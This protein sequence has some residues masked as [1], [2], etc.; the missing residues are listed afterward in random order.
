MSENDHIGVV[1]SHRWIGAEAQ[2]KRLEADGCRTIIAL[3]GKKDTATREE[4]EKLTRP[5][6]T[7]KL[8]H[9][10]LLADPKR[11]RLKGG[12]KAD[13]LAALKR[14]ICKQP[15]GRGG[16]LKDVASGLTTANP[17]HKRLIIAG[18][19]DH[20]TRDGK[21]LKSAL[22]GARNRGRQRGEYSKEA[23]A[24]AY[25]IWRNTVDYPEWDDVDAAYLA[26]DKKYNH[27]HPFTR[28]R[29]SRKWP[30]GRKSKSR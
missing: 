23:W 17:E 30:G 12:L 8:V 18:A 29:A 20:I 4:L 26:L 5:T 22:N 21:G 7:I 3:D 28:Y 1:R 19:N 24:E 2:R 10:F 13:F 6:T 14:L 9:A 16:T 15:V 25:S 27:E 11:R